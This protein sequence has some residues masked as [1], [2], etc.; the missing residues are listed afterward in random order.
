MRADPQFIVSMATVLVAGLLWL[1]VVMALRKKGF[2]FL[3]FFT[4]FYVYLFKVLDYTLFQYQSLLV[5]KQWMPNLRLN[6]L[7]ASDSLNLIPLFELTPA[8]AT[9]SLLNILMLVPFGF[10]LPF[11]TRLRMKGVVLSGALFSIL[12]EL[13]QLST[14]ILAR[15]TFR[16]ADINDVIF[17]TT[18]AAI[19]YLMFAGFTRGYRRVSSGWG[20]RM[21]PVLRHIA[22]RPQINRQG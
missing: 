15:T 4:V 9:T 20:I 8:D 21:H 16:V 13:M 14:G 3:A 12:I 10:G 7:A 17:N 18:G 1:A 2:A 11:I 6:G 19:G 5:L 22:E